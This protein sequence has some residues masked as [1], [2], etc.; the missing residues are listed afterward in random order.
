[1][2]TLRIKHPTT[3]HASSNRALWPTCSITTWSRCRLPLSNE[4]L[5]D[6]RNAGRGSHPLPNAHRDIA[7]TGTAGYRARRSYANSASALQPGGND[8]PPPIGT[9]ARPIR[10]WVREDRDEYK[11]Q[12]K[13]QETRAAKVPSEKVAPPKI[14]RPRKATGKSKKEDRGSER[15]D[16]IG[17]I[18][19]DVMTSKAI[20]STGTISNSGKS[21]PLIRVAKSAGKTKK[22]KPVM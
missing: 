12:G 2:A 20:K 17:E 19:D 13:R 3:L 15:S 7:S 22:G 14:P 18:N 4:G 11:A 6:L 1:M 21:V 5:N 10:S 16:K 8:A 9:L